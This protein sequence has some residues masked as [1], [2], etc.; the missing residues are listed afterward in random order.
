VPDEPQGNF[1][2]APLPPSALGQLDGGRRVL[3]FDKLG[4]PA[5]GKGETGFAFTSLGEG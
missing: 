1:P 5:F 2:L 3:S 4:Q